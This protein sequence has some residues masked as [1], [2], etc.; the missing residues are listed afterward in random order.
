ML[1]KKT[2]TIKR[3]PRLKKCNYG[4][5]SSWL[6][7]FMA[8]LSVDLLL[9]KKYTS[10]LHAFFFL[11]GAGAHAIIGCIATILSFLQMTIAFFR[12]SLQSNWSVQQIVFAEGTID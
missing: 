12:P 2:T 3:I 6:S 8:F 11:Q 4:T 1:E 7:V 9:Y 10:K 5:L